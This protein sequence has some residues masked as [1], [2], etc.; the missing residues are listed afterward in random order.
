MADGRQASC[1]GQ[2]GVEVRVE[3]VLVH[4]IEKVRRPLKHAV[5]VG[6]LATQVFFQV[7]VAV[8]ATVGL[9]GRRAVRLHSRRGL[10]SS[11]VLYW[12]IRI[13]Q[14]GG[15]GALFAPSVG[16]RQQRLADVGRLHKHVFIR[17][18]VIGTG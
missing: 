17:F 8:E 4:H 3:S 6:R 5:E 16:R 1:H 18:D 15:G 7:V 9:G 13:A 11:G 14:P 2:L 10:S 12:Q